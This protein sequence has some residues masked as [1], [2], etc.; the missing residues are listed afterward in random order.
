MK[1]ITN[2]ILCILLVFCYVAD[3]LGMPLFII[4]LTSR[5]TNAI[6]WAIWTTFIPLATF[7]IAIPST[8]GILK[9]LADEKKGGYKKR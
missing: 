7:V 6:D 8:V 9:Y 3:I 1:K 4:F 2:F 5:A